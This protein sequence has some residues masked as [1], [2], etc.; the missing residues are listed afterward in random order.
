MLKEYLPPLS[1]LSF[2]G[3]PG[4]LSTT[5]NR[6]GGLLSRRSHWVPRLTTSNIAN[7][8]ITAATH[9]VPLPEALM[10]RSLNETGLPALAERQIFDLC[11][12]ATNLQEHLPRCRLFGLLL[13]GMGYTSPPAEHSI[14]DA[15]TSDIR[16]SEEEKKAMSL[17]AARNGVQTPEARR[18]RAVVARADAMKRKAREPG[19]NLNCFLS[20]PRMTFLEGILRDDAL[21]T[22]NTSDTRHNGDKSL[23][24]GGDALNFYLKAISATS[25]A[26]HDREIIVDYVCGFARSLAAGAEAGALAKVTYTM[27]AREAIKA[28]A[29]E[30]NDRAEKRRAR[31]AAAAA[32]VASKEGTVDPIAS[33]KAREKKYIYSNGR[34]ARDAALARPKPLFPT[35]N[36]PEEEFEWWHVSPGLMFGETAITGPERQRWFGGGGWRNHD[37]QSG[38]QRGSIIHA[39]IDLFYPPRSA[40]ELLSRVQYCQNGNRK[41]GDHST[42]LKNANGS[43]TAAE[44]ENP[45]ERSRKK[46]YGEG[47]TGSVSAESIRGRKSQINDEKEKS[48]K[49]ERNE[50]TTFSP[51]AVEKENTNSVSKRRLTISQRFPG[52]SI[53]PFLPFALERRRKS[54][55]RL[56]AQSELFNQEDKNKVQEHQAYLRGRELLLRKLVKAARESQMKSLPLEQRHQ[57]VEGQGIDEKDKIISKYSPSW[58]LPH[59]D[60][61]DFLFR[62][63]MIWA[64]QRV[65]SQR[66]TAET[67]SHSIDSISNVTNVSMKRKYGADGSRSGEGENKVLEENKYFLGKLASPSI[68]G[69]LCSAETAKQVEFEEDIRTL[70]EQGFGGSVKGGL[71]KP[72]PDK[73]KTTKKSGKGVL[74]GTNLPAGFKPCFR[75]NWSGRHGDQRLR[76]YGIWEFAAIQAAIQQGFIATNNPS[77]STTFDKKKSRSQISVVLIKLMSEWSLATCPSLSQRAVTIATEHTNHIRIRLR[78]QWH[79]Y[80]FRVATHLEELLVAA[81]ESFKR[82]RSNEAVTS[83]VSSDLKD[84]ENVNISG[85]IES[86]H[87][88]ESKDTLNASTSMDS[89]VW[90]MY[91]LEEIHRALCRTNVLDD[92]INEEKKNSDSDVSGL[93]TEKKSLTSSHLSE[94]NLPAMEEAAEKCMEDIRDCVRAEVRN[95]EELSDLSRRMRVLWANIACA[96]DRVAEDIQSTS[97]IGMSSFVRDEW[98]T[99][100]KPVVQ[101][102]N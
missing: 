83:I 57:T 101:R 37:Y 55:S 90:C 59:V 14:N 20:A 31:K 71:S 25:K 92:A 49:E 78:H 28:K 47:R 100:R 70:T 36:Q 29:N 7:V 2:L 98:A 91:E 63:M 80:R 11:F 56:P 54:L 94:D 64:E 10:I 46:K 73:G 40:P 3:R 74:N 17:I 41:P 58:S 67:Y 19:T 33:R 34:R 99:G 38:G 50:S 35:T 62:V 97:L 75:R 45:T 66:R 51:E 6:G 68:D 23:V 22:F 85:E 44:I 39:I 12:N 26:Q 69:A 21:R 42:S 18:A 4:L 102:K 76:R 9:K 79:Q 95:N 81:R 65:A 93:A 48:S 15:H 77:Y 8:L 53:T 84:R 52:I 16:L 61:D 88:S 86:G 60:I 32:A 96:Q 5:K 24:R 30:N 72:K 87:Q 89:V 1:I 43:S 13:G 27:H 82:K